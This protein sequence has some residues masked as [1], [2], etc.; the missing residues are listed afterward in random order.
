MLVA[1]LSGDVL[2]ADETNIKMF[3]ALKI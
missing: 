2:A 1:V 3:K